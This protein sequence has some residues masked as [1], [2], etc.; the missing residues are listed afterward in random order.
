[1]KPGTALKP[2]FAAAAIALMMISGAW[3]S[4]EQVLLS[5]N[6][7]AGDG[8]GPQA[9][10]VF[11]A[12]GNLYGST[13]GGGANTL[14]TIFQL[15]PDGAGGWTENIIWDFTGGTDG[16]LPITSLMFDSLGNLYGTATTGG[17]L[18]SCPG[19]C[20][21][22]FELSPPPAPG[23]WIETTLY[24]FKNTD[25]REPHGDVV[26]DA[27]GNLYG[28]TRVGGGHNPGVVFQ[29]TP[30]GGLWTEK[31]LHNFAGRTDDG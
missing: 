15:V 26:F 29:L 12:K 31:V 10:V 19:G 17:D 20:G 30:S 4:T 3:G 25:G 16:A 27:A 28:T 7:F 11:D 18:V 21:V 13:G 2:M 5:F 6:A 24:S 8:I 9:N 1:M 14:G 23:K 22:V